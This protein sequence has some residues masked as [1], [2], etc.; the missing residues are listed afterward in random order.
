MDLTKETLGLRFGYGLPLSAGTQTALE[1]VIA[2][3]T[4][5]DLAGQTWRLPSLEIFAPKVAQL[6]VLQR[7]SHDGVNNT[8][9]H[10]AALNEVVGFAMLGFR[11][12]FARA[13]DTPQPLRERL[14][15]FFADH[16]TVI[17]K[18]G[19]S[20]IYL[21]SALVEDAIRP[22]IGGSF[23]QML[24]AVTLHPAMLIYLDQ[25]VSIG[26]NSRMGLKQGK[27]LNENLARELMELHT[28]G[29]GGG[30]SQIDVR[31]LAEL[32]TGLTVERDLEVV[33]E[34]KRVEPGAEEV[35]G[36]SYGGNKIAAI[37]NVLRDLALHPATA[38]HMARKL[39]VHFLSDSPDPAVIEAMRQAY[40]QSGGDIPAVMRAMLSHPAAQG[41]GAQKVRQPFDFISA[42]CRA[43]GF[44]GADVMAMKLGEFK[45]GFLFSMEQMGQRLKS[46]PGPN[47]FPEEAEAWVSPPRLAARIDWAMR[48]PQHLV[49]ELPDP[50]LFAKGALGGNA[51]QTLLTAAS[52]AEN[53]RDGV[54]IVLSSPEFNRR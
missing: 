30:Y 50:V 38:A 43:L 25:H 14:I 31:Q 37:Q 32:L 9:A 48:M 22:H 47:G 24:E 35:M 8:A 6:Q 12:A 7:Q 40:E 28:L 20:D 44:T 15:T 39:A 51:S 41:Q 42:A 4:G 11:T 45:R 10:D 3:L 13:I 26:P 27:G 53:R 21:P 18:S 5:P 23:G 2:S 49:K 46:A 16:F 34:A 29:V 19:A 52:R 1:A 33:F 54:G 36:K 17:A